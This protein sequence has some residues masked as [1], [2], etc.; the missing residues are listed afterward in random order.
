MSCR[1]E[2]PDLGYAFNALEP[3]ID[4]KTME[5]H[6]TK[7]HQTY[8]NN[9]AKALETAPDEWKKSCP[10]RLIKNLEKMPKEIQTPVRNSAGGHVNHSLFWKILTPGGENQAIGDLAGA[11]DRDFGSFAEFKTQFTQVATTCFGSGW[12][13]LC[14]DSN[15]KLSVCSTANQD[16]PA[17][18]AFANCCG[19]KA[20]LG[21]DVWEHSYYLK[22]QNRRPE[23][24]E[25]FFNLINWTI[26]SESYSKKCC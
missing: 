5:I 14:K 12:A 21:L 26:V 2:L 20:I 16:N 25:A 11:I 18:G 22:Y 13:W 19:N 9:L 17:M 4:A 24:I 23:Y 3:H 7:H 1:L 8:I 6:Y 10:C 15:G